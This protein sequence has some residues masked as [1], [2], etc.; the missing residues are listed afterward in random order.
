M[1]PRRVRTRSPNNFWHGVCQALDNPGGDHRIK[2]TK[3]GYDID[4]IQ[5]L[6]MQVTILLYC[7]GRSV[8][9]RPARCWK[10]QRNIGALVMVALRD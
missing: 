2:D 8:L 6:K 5:Y 7:S 9:A 4:T 3:I 10:F 1:G